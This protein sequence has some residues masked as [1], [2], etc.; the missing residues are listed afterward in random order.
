M[1]RIAALM[2]ICLFVLLAG[3]LG[4]ITARRLLHPQ[5]SLNVDPVAFER[6]QV[7]NRLDKL[8][9]EQVALEH[10]LH[11]LQEA[12]AIKQGPQMLPKDLTDYSALQEIHQMVQE[13]LF[14]KYVKTTGSIVNV[15]P[16]SDPYPIGQ[17]P[18]SAD[19]WKKYATRNFD[20]NTENG[21]SYWELN[22]FP[23][24]QPNGSYGI[25]IRRESI[26]SVGGTP[27]NP[28]DCDEKKYSQRV[29]EVAAFYKSLYP[30]EDWSDPCARIEVSDPLPGLNQASESIS[31]S[32][33]TLQTVSVPMRAFIF[34][35]R[36]FPSLAPGM[37]D[38]GHPLVSVIVTR[39]HGTWQP[40]LFEWRI[41]A[42]TDQRNN[43]EVTAQEFSGFQK[44]VN[45]LVE[46]FTKQAQLSGGFCGYGDCY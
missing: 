43:G 21:A 11:V 22:V 10:D 41:V 23:P 36:K 3:T 28:I 20:W 46:L 8:E 44:D 37:Y 40:E 12:P 35:Q 45:N 42:S 13:R 15:V 1:K 27:P 17:I 25:S 4:W 14:A 39:D 18:F 16:F 30:D 34:R 5:P 32:S 31:V 33:T 29:R 19:F 9:N 6:M 2:G 7:L 24:A 38:S 26:D